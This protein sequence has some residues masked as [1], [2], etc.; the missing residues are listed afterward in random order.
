MKTL[1]QKKNFVTRELRISEAKLFC[2]VSKF[3][4]TNEIDMPFENIDGEKVSFK[5]SNNVLLLVSMGLNLLSIINLFLDFGKWISLLGFAIATILFVIYWLSIG[6]FWQVKL[7]DGNSILI[8]KDI[9]DAKTVDDFI[10][11]IIKARNVYL[12]ENFASIDENLDYESQLNNF[13]WLK[14]IKAITKEEFETKHEELKK[15]FFHSDLNIGFN[16]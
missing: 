3:G 8:L 4:N 9:P 12:R 11:E 6:D 13:K 15:I 10:D 7:M 14:A 5:S 2:K 16:K 1:I